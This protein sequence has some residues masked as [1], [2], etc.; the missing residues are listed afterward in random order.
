VPTIGYSS[1]DG[2]RDS[3][4]DGQT[5][6]LVDS[7]GGLITALAGLLDD[8]E[9]RREL[10]D[11]ARERSRNFSWDLTGESWKSLLKRIHRPRR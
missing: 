10:G 4:V 6:L 5:G 9:R 8:P 3:V 2:L 1:S 7:E 11:A